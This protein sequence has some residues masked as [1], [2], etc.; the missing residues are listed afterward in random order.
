LTVVPR[1]R[2]QLVLG[3][4]APS[5]EFYFDRGIGGQDFEKPTAVQ[6]VDVPPDQKQQPT[7]AVEI[8]AVEAKIGL[9]SVLWDRVH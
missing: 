9:I 4:P 5:R 2:H 1:P 7:A 6:G 3:H 8:A